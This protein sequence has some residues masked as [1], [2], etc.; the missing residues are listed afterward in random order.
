MFSAYS[1][2]FESRGYTLLSSGD[3][4]CTTLEAGPGDGPGRRDVVVGCQPNL[5]LLPLVES[6]V[7]LKPFCLRYRS[8]RLTDCKPH[9]FVFNSRQFR[10]SA[11]CF[12]GVK[13]KRTI[14]NSLESCHMLW[15]RLS[16]W[17]TALSYGKWVTS[18]KSSVVLVILPAR[19]LE[20]DEW[21]GQSWEK[22]GQGFWEVSELVVPQGLGVKVNEKL[23]YFT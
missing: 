6:F 13:S 20:Q 16:C 17:L 5:C 21:K 14:F 4:A 2:S 1:L 9:A 18:I 10:A 3:F 7:L 12:N 22:K 15:C 11:A 19:L 23:Q 8:L